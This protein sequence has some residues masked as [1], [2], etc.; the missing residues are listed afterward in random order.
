MTTDYYDRKGSRA[1]DGQP[2]FRTAEDA[3]AE[4]EVAA[5]LER[6]WNC[7]VHPFGKLSP[8]DWWMERAGHMVAVGEL[9]TRQHSTHDYPTV[10]LNLR[11]WCSLMMMSVGTN[12]PAYYIVKLTD[13]IFWTK[14]SDIDATNIKIGG[15]SRIVKS[16]SDIEPII[17]IPLTQLTRLK[18]AS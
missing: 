7:Q 1:P 10:F 11:K 4:A 13:G 17:L 3:K 8:V 16:H 12:V 5:I 9:K 18:S 15:C 14:V 6:A 2:V